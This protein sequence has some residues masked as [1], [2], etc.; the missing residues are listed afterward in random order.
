[1]IS[2]HLKAGAT[3]RVL[4]VFSYRYDA[5]LVPALI[6]NIEPMTDGWVAYDDRGGEG[7]FSNEVQR[8]LALLQAAREAGAKW[9]LAIDPDERFE[10]RLAK[11]IRRLADA[12]GSVAHTFAVREMYGPLHYRVDGMW[13]KK[14][15]ARLL[16]LNAGVTA[17]KGELHTS[18]AAFIPNARINDTDINL[19][20]LKMITQERRQAR[21][22]L[23]N[24]L[25][26]DRRMQSVGYDYLADEAGAKFKRVPFWR[27]YHP[28][29]QEDGGLWMAEAPPRD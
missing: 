28:P 7:L 20:H 1:V 26:P 24:H 16:S 14:R 3:P 4:A 10:A 21:A 19:Y 8:R 18:W 23:Y 9:A 27:G 22:A 29:H 15:Q 25:D 5:H 2:V 17:P 13:G 12:E 6:A 11:A